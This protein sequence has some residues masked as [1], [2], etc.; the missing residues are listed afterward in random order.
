MQEIQYN[1][2]AVDNVES[3][4]GRVGGGRTIFR[5][6]LSYARMNAVDGKMAIKEEGGFGVVEERKALQYVLTHSL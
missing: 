4:E 3:R 2:G 5:L 6:R 1:A